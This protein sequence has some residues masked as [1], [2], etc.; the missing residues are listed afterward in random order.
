MSVIEEYINKVIQEEVEKALEKMKQSQTIVSNSIKP[1]YTNKEM[2]KLLG[3]DPK[4]M[5]KYRDDG[6]IGFTHQD[7]KY[8]YTYQDL[9]GFLMN[10]KLR[11]E[12]FR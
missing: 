10:K 9:E 4:T 3:V 7:D 12:A 11:N 2:M 1:V 8:F 6:W 5:K